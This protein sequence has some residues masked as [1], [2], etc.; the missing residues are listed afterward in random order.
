MVSPYFR[1]Q[2]QRLRCCI[3]TRRLKLFERLR[4][5]GVDALAL[6]H[7]LFIR[8]GRAIVLLTNFQTQTLSDQRWQSSRTSFRA[9]KRRYHPEHVDPLGRQ[10]WPTKDMQ[11]SWDQALLDFQE[12]LI[13]IENTLIALGGC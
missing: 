5:T 10:R 2:R 12:L 11:S 3:D 6:L 1:V 8:R 4:N 7:V 9:I 13:E